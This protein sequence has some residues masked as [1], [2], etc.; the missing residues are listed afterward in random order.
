A[1]TLKIKDGD[2][3][4]VESKI[5]KTKVKAKLFAGAKPDIVSMPFE[6]GHKRFGR[7]AEKRG[8]NPNEILAPEF[9]HL[10]GL[11]SFYS[12]RVKVYKA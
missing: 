8:V 1:A 5:G 12:T 2:L 11:C 10:G 7:W 4:W 6:Y 3:V 9:D